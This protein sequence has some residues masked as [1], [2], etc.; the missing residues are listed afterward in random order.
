MLAI[1][2]NRVGK[3]N[4][5]QFRIV[6]QEH[7]AVPGGRHVEILGSYDPHLKKGVFK[8]ERIKYWI[9]NGAQVSDSVY[10][11]FIKQ[12]IVTDKKRHIKI[13]KKKKKGEEEEAEKPSSAS[14]DTK[15]T[16][17]KKEE[18]KVEAKNESPEKPAENKEAKPGVGEA[19]KE[20]G[21]KAEAKKKEVKESPSADKKEEKQDKKEE[22]K[23]DQ[24]KK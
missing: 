9:G 13:G 2:F 19:K 11:L 21:D 4:K 17:D 10:N 5:A 22:S 1:R 23:Q 15:A 20:D 7:T 12:G 3:K 6:V 8:N 18:G 24:E 14:A 16:E